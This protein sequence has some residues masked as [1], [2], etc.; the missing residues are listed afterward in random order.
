MR[1]PAPSRAQ[2]P[3]T[4][5]TSP[6]FCHGAPRPRLAA[7]DLD[8]TRPF[9]RCLPLPLSKRRLFGL[10]KGAAEG[11]GFTS[12]TS[13]PIPGVLGDISRASTHARQTRERC[14]QETYSP[15][16]IFS[17]IHC[18]HGAREPTSLRRVHKST[19]RNGQRPAGLPPP[20][21]CTI[22]PVRLF[23]GV[24][25]P[26]RARGSVPAGEEERAVRL[27]RHP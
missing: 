16:S 3:D 27:H 12:Q 22:I 1:A 23:M 25:H 7:P 14:R 20:L 13:A 9:R 6:R 24:V 26:M 8:L 4:E 21:F 15:D 17:R 10:R 11:T 5:T 2:V 18:G 19:R